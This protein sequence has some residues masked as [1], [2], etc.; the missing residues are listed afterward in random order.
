MTVKIV[1]S[2]SDIEHYKLTQ[3]P[4]VMDLMPSHNK[5]DSG[6]H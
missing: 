6:H 5:F 3:A 2:D 4:N 1:L